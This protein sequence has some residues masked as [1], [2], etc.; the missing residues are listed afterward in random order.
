MKTPA[1]LLALCALLPV[2]GWA[3]SKL[4]ME[5]NNP[6]IGLLTVEDELAS[7]QIVI[8]LTGMND[9]TS[10]YRANGNQWQP[11][12]EQ[13]ETG[14]IAKTKRSIESHGHTSNAGLFVYDSETKRA[15][16]ALNGSVASLTCRG[17]RKLQQIKGRAPTISASFSNP[18]LPTQTILVKH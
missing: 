3:S 5:C 1:L 6:G 18:L 17:K 12:L 8:K 14:L 4:I 7:E 15:F 10:T 9:K 2:S 11:V 16:F 13:L